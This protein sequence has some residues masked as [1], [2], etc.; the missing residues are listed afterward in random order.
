M[1]F[2][3]VRFSMTTPLSNFD[4]SKEPLL[5]LLSDIQA[6]KIQLVDFQRS[7][8][9][10]EARIRQLLASVSLGFP[11][12][13]IMLLKNNQK[14]FQ[15]RLVEGLQLSQA[16]EPAFLILDGQ[17]RLTSLFMTLLS[18]NPVLIDKGKR[19]QLE[20]RWFYLDIGKALD[21]PITP[22]AEAIFSVKADYRGSRK[23]IDWLT[24]EKEFIEG[25]FP[26]SR[27]FNFSDWRQKFS[28]YWE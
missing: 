21:Y 11:V 17:Q 27:V 4:I 20:K 8:C 25:L 12:G 5:D 6:G 22:R 14:S 18:N 10:D 23:N 16:P 24:P 13:S 3:T 7:W 1:G 2:Q 26:L 15:S 28:E 9:W 19:H